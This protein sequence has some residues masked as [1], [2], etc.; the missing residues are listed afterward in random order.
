MCLKVKCLQYDMGL[1]STCSLL[2]SGRHWWAIHR[3]RWPEG[4][5]SA[6]TL[7]AGGLPLSDEERFIITCLQKSFS[8]PLL[9]HN[10][11][12]SSLPINLTR[13]FSRPR[14]C[15]CSGCQANPGSHGRCVTLWFVHLLFLH[16]G[17]CTK[18]VENNVLVFFP[19]ASL[20][21]RRGFDI[22]LEK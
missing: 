18:W 11:H 1:V 19:I 7:V 10:S 22:T 13:H 2:V 12:Y 14:L 3:G 16:R 8:F 4:R 6:R 5:G 21:V 17:V 9:S 15:G 20:W